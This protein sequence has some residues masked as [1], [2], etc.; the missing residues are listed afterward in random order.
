MPSLFYVEPEPGVWKY[1]WLS[2]L[3]IWLTLNVAPAWYTIYVNK[4]IRPVQNLD[5]KFKPFARFDYKNWS[6]V[7]VLFTHFFFIPRYVLCCLS[8]LSL[9][10][11]TSIV[12]IGHK[13]GTP[14]K[15]WQLAIIRNWAIYASGVLMFIAGYVAMRKKPV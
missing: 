14:L 15:R 11:V 9:V 6:Y 10:I 5:P 1:S 7:T 13:K 3:L 2:W 4:K 12:L 8:W